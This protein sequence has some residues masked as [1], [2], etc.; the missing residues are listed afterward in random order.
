MGFLRGISG[1]GRL[2]V[3]V[4]VGV[5]RGR[6]PEKHK[7]KMELDPMLY[8][9]DR[10]K[11]A[12]NSSNTRVSSVSSCRWGAHRC[13]GGYQVFSAC[14]YATAH[15]GNITGKPLEVRMLGVLCVQHAWPREVAF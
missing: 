4:S 10:D 11:H 1:L 8:S 12:F 9:H 15:F 2:C 7:N 14:E 3:G 5:L 6:N 13:R